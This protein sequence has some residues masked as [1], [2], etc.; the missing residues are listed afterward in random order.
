TLKN[1]IKDQWIAGSGTPAVLRHAVTG[2]PIAQCSSQGV[3]FRAAVEHARSVGGPALRALTF[4]QRADL[5]KKLAG[6]LNEKLPEFYTIAATYGATKADAWIDIE[7]G[8]GNLFAY[9]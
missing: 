3:D 6:A 7:G 9:A 5:L 8:I 4:H 2:E 1:Y